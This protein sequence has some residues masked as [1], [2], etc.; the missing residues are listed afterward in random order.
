MAGK[1]LINEMGTLFCGSPQEG[2]FLSFRMERGHL[3][4]RVVLRFFTPFRMTDG[5]VRLPRLRLV[6][7]RITNSKLNAMTGGGEVASVSLFDEVVAA[8]KKK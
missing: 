7:A 4:L 6:M 1:N 5:Y 2:V 8:V 3:G